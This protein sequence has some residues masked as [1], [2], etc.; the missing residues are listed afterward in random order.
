MKNFEIFINNLKRLRQIYDL[1]KTDLSRKTGIPRSSLTGYEKGSNEPTLSV[2]FKIAE[3]FNISVQTLTTID[4][5]SISINGDEN[6]IKE[7]D[8]SINKSENF[9][10]PLLNELFSKDNLGNMK[11][12]RKEYIE[13]LDKLTD[14]VNNVLPEKIKTLE[15]VIQL[16]ES[17][18]SK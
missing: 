6:L 3:A 17:E 18:I 9:S 14:V 12:L 10:E 15:K 8:K 1:N 4:I 2:I 13:E 16:I 11:K 5:S 7:I